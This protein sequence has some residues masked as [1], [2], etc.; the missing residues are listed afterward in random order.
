MAQNGHRTDT[1]M[2]VTYCQWTSSSSAKKETPGST[3]KRDVSNPASSIGAM[4]R[5]VAH[6]RISL[7]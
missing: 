6:E 7:R 1:D 2:A 3:D 4:T 5:C